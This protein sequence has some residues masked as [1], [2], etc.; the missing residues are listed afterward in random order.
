MVPLFCF[1][2]AGGSV[3]CFQ[4][5]SQGCSLKCFLSPFKIS[6][7]GFYLFFRLHFLPLP[8]SLSFLSPNLPLWTPLKHL[9][10]NLWKG[11]TRTT[12]LFSPG[13]FLK[14]EREERE[15]HTFESYQPLD[16]MSYLNIISCPP[17]ITSPQGKGHACTCAMENRQSC[18]HLAK[19]ERCRCTLLIIGRCEWLFWGGRTGAGNEWGFL[20][21]PLKKET[22]QKGGGSE[23]SRLGSEKYLGFLLLGGIAVRIDACLGSYPLEQHFMEHFESRQIGFM[24]IEKGMTHKHLCSNHSMTLGN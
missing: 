16:L 13:S 23:L 6:L 15:Q 19:V 21:R 18:W 4:T 8:L 24:A 11:L 9:S 2:G 17:Y 10:P 12:H 5:V 14:R 20:G 7:L 1:G 22:S 3:Q